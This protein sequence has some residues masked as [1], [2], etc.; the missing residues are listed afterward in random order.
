MSLQ[1][2]AKEIV[3]KVFGPVNASLVDVFAQEIN[4]ETQPIDFLE[5]CISLLASMLG[6]D[7][8]RS[9]F[10]NLLDRF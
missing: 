1:A 9:K 5:K 10:K 6:A 2:E 4:P 7:L 3:N 8:A